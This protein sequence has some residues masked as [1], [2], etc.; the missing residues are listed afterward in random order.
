MRV[1]MDSL[2]ARAGWSSVEDAQLKKMAS[3]IE[4][5]DGDRLLNTAAA[6]LSR[7]F[8]E[9]FRVEIPTIDIDGTVVDPQEAKIDVSGHPLYDWGDGGPVHITGTRIEVEVPFTGEALAF[10]IRPTRSFLSL[11]RG[12][13]KGSKLILQ[14][15]GPNLQHSEVKKEIDGQLDQVSKLLDNLRM[16]AEKMNARL[17]SIALA[18]IQKRSAKLLSD[19]NL[20][21]S[22]GFKIKKREGAAT[23][24]S[25]PEVRRKIIPKM[26][27]ASSAQ[28]APEPALDSQDYE[29]ILSIMDNMARV[30]ELSPSAFKTIKEEDL[31]THFLVQLNSQYEGQATGETF[32]YEGKTDILIR[33]NGRNIFIAE[34]KYWG[35]PKMLTATIDQLLGYSSWRDTK[36]AVIVFNR[37]KGFTEVL[38]SIDATAKAHPNFKRDSGNRS[39]S[40]FRY[41]FSH[42]DDSNREMTLTVMAFDVPT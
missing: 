6:E 1:A 41:V 22:L 23:T 37:N 25:A 2:F 12:V 29:H 35:G 42:R 24:F 18:A 19:R 16:D 31:R 26:P 21:A 10:S 20:A 39:E 11:P 28:F 3:E 32:N 17:E 8:A 7:Y 27:V 15:S 36:V 9:K 4:S 13:I 33:S 30:M 34:C 5:I 14:V 40:S 38:K